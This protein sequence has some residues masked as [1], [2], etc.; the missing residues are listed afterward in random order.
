MS[1]T[2]LIGQA[3]SVLMCASPCLWA[4]CACALSGVAR[5]QPGDRYRSFDPARRERFVARIA[6]MLSDPRCTQACPSGHC[7]AAEAHV[8]LHVT[9]SRDNWPVKSCSVHTDASTL[10][11]LLCELLY[12]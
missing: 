5:A 10:L 3:G 6:G 2:G 11:K 4:R 7:H 8:G 1:L 12:L 9:C